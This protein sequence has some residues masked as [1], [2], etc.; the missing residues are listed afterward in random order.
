M[1]ATCCRITG[2]E[3]SCF[4][5]EL[6][7]LHYERVRRTGTTDDPPSRRGLAS[8]RSWKGDAATYT[9][10]HLRMSSRPRPAAC[11]TCGTTR[12]RFEWALRPDAPSAALLVAPQ[13]W[14]YSTD[15][16]HYA[17]LCK[18]CHN[19]L[20]LTVLVCKRGHRL[21]DEANVYV[22]PS[23]GK[24]FCRPCQVDRRRQRTLRE[25]ATTR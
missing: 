17:N 18:P 14:R 19:K 5:K 21:D 7:R 1:T 25:Q 2:C 22:Q 15:P 10:V 8:G 9:A 6:C 11:E 20:D 23:N 13:G 3:R 16:A 24:R 12:G 4:C